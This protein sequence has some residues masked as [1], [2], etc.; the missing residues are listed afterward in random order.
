MDVNVNSEVKGV[1]LTLV[2]PAVERE[3][4]ERAPVTPVAAGTNATA[5]ALGDKELHR[6]Q[7]GRQQKDAVSAEDLAKVVEEIQNRLDAMG[8]RLNFALNKEPEVVVVKVTDRLSGE[9]VRQIPSEEVLALRKKL[10][11]LS[12]LLFDEKA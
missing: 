3:D 4:R 2:A 6:R 10:Q 9:L 1:G 5:G 11:E 12:G 7:N 8:T